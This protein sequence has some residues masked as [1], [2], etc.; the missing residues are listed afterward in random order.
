MPAVVDLAAMRDAMVALGGDPNKI[1]PLVPV[2][3]V[4][5][6][7]VVVDYF[8]T[9]KSLGQNVKREYEQNQERYRFLK[10][11][12]QAF[13][14]FSRRAARHRHL[15]SGQSRI[16][17]PDR[18]DR[19]GEARRQDGRSRLSRYAG[20][21]RQPHHHGQRPRGARLGRR[22]HRGGGGDA[23][24]AAVDAAARSDRLQADWRIARGRHR[25]RSRADRHPDAAQEGRGRQVRR[26][27][28]PRP[29]RDDGR[30]SRDARQYGPGIRR[31]LR[32]V[33][34]RQPDARPTSRPPAAS[35]RGWLWSRP[36]PRRRASTAPAL[37]PIPCSPTR[38][39][40]SSARSRPRSP[41]RS[42][43]RTASSSA[44]AKAGFAS[45]MESEFK[46]APEHRRAPQGR[47][48]E[49]RSRPWRRRHRG[50]HVMHQH[51]QSERDDGGRA[52]GAQ[53]R[54][55]G[56]DRQAV[57]EDLARARQPGGRRTI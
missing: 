32:P 12:Q 11:G 35:R 46:Q 20:R 9:S 23:R 33:P 5:D 47:G 52:S 3:L 29:Q 34:D 48:D 19:E 39:N 6:H 17:R 24:P 21:H 10:W 42:G 49:L 8:G 44:D 50:D 43:R 54:R 45:A 14:N 56:S 53:R 22:R 16:S 37:P 2:D 13:S 28:R 1:N 25:D 30:R 7:S 40:S 18:L 51:L 15:P 26:V 4:I 41:A 27:L 57:G 38:S 55:Q 36:T 31:D